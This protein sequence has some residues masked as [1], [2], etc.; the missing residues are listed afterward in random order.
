RDRSTGVPSGGARLSTIRREE[1]TFSAPRRARLDASRR[2]NS[3]HVITQ[4]EKEPCR[5]DHDD[6]TTMYGTRLQERTAVSRAPAV[7]R[8]V[9]W[10]TIPHAAERIR[11]P[12]YG[13]GQAASR[14]VEGRSPRLGAAVH[15]RNQSW[16][17][18]RQPPSRSIH[19]STQLGDVSAFLDAYLER[20]VKPAG[21][22]S[23]NSVR[24]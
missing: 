18:P 6:Q 4:R 8:H 20:C 10:E 23:I 15:R 19:V 13:T 24:R 7:R 21:L 9:A 17:D 5:R 22:R 16:T 14:P 1:S 11:D 3:S 2:T 12:T